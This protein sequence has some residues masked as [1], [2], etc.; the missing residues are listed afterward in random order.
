MSVIMLLW[1]AFS[2]KMKARNY[3]EQKD[4]NSTYNFNS[5]LLIY[6]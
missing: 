6:T 2:K 5:Q 1:N 4:L 3:Q